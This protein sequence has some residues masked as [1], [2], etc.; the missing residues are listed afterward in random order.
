MEA[1]TSRKPFGGGSP[2]DLL[3]TRKGS[4]LL[5]ALSAL[6]AGVLIFLFVDSRSSGG[7]LVGGGSSQVLVAKALI[8]TG[9]SGDVIAAQ[10]LTSV[11]TVDADDLKTGAIADPGTLAGKAA[12]AD[13]Y[14]GQQLTAADFGAAG[15]VTSKLTGAQRAVAVPV[16]AAHG[17]IGNVTT[18]DRVDVYVGVG[19]GGQRGG[20]PIIRTLLQNVLVLGA[21]AATEGQGSNIILR[22]DDTD[23][24]KLAFAADNGRVWIALR[25]PV[26]ADQTRPSTVTLSSLLASGSSVPEGEE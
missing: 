4:L 1:S 24:A 6:I 19:G 25:P 26:G 17:L 11:T 23:A 13:I 12:T 15:A 22:A 18:G 9:S 7:G 14:P 5:A 8:P 21:P 20:E 16:D 3:A 10:Q 2:R